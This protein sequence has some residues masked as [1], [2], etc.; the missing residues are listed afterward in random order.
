MNRSISGPANWRVNVS[1]VD[2]TLG[3]P[4][5]RSVD[6]LWLTADHWPMVSYWVSI[7][8]LICDSLDEQDAQ[9]VANRTKTTLGF[10]PASCN[11]YRFPDWHLAVR[12]SQTLSLSDISEDWSATLF[13]IFSSWLRTFRYKACLHHSRFRPWWLYL[14]QRIAISSSLS[15]GPLI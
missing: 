2:W 10:S 5:H 11:Y 15:P 14:I 9:C 13:I 6:R 12:T 7:G 8:P 3:R 1:C 4:M